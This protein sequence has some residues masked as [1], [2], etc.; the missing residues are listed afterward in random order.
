MHR[1]ALSA[2]GSFRMQVHAILNEHGGTLRT[3]DLDQLSDLMRD[4][5][6]LHGHTIEI[7]RVDGS[8]IGEAIERAAN[9]SDIDVLLVGGGDGTVSSAAGALMNRPI[10]LGILPAGT[11][12]L[13]ARTLQIPLDLSEAVNALS[14]GEVTAVDIATVNGRPF[15]HQFSVGLHARMVR[16]R[17]R[18]DYGSKFGKMWATT[19]AIVTTL[20]SLPLVRLQMEID[21]RS[22][23]I[24]S[25]AIAVSNN[26]YGEGHLPY[27]NDPT[28]GVL[29]VYICQVI[30]PLPAA[31]MTLD[32]IRGAWRDNPGVRILTAKKIRMERSGGRSKD[33]SVQDG[34]LV[35]L[36]EVSEVEIHEKAL[37][38][39]VPR[40]ATFLAVASPIA[41]E[42]E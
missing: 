39:L 19:R 6:A 10:A 37:R 23:W 22:Q 40:E 1:A 33:R 26:L 5:F 12:N 4:E 35:D 42:T 9:R 3:T 30:D 41:T 8:G 20:R 28:G 17:E 36:D 29:G 2:F 16:A 21:G 7:E 14:S 32:M 31:R 38:V 24:E 25:P 15:V 27:A 13:F 34:E 18:Y 11:M